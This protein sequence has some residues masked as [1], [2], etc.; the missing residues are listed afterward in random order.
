MYIKP[1]AK[2]KDDEKIFKSDIV[3]W[4]TLTDKDWCFPKC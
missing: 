4:W 3:L 2:R 1:G